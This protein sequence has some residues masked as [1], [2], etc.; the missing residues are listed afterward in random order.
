[1][2]NYGDAMAGRSNWAASPMARLGLVGM[3]FVIGAGIGWWSMPNSAVPANDSSTYIGVARNLTSDEQR[4]HG[5][6]SPFSHELSGLSPDEAVANIGHQPVTAWPPLYPASLAA[7]SIV[8]LSIESV[9]RL[10]NV[11][12]FGI[13][14]ALSAAMVLRL[15]GSAI[16][17]GL[18]AVLFSC[19]ISTV[20]VFAIAGTEPLYLA[21]QVGALAV[22]GS[23]ARR[24]T[25]GGCV[26]FVA[27]AAGAALTRYVGVAVVATGVLMVWTTAA[28]VSRVRRL[29][30]GAGMALAALPVAAWLLNVRNVPGFHGDLVYQHRFDELTGTIRSI[31]E[32]FVPQDQLQGWRVPLA[33][34]GGVVVVGLS[35]L[36]FAT[37][38]RRSPSRPVDAPGA[39][40][41]STHPADTMETRDTTDTT[42]TTGT[43]HGHIASLLEP[44][45]PDLR[46]AATIIVHAVLYEI[47]VLISASFADHA[48]PLGYRLTLPLAPS[49]LALVFA[50]TERALRAIPQRTW[51]I[52]ACSAIAMLV[53]VAIG[54]Q[55]RDSYDRVLSRS[56][57]GLWSTVPSSAPIEAVRALPSTT[58]VFTNQPSAI[59]GLTGRP[60]LALPLVTSPMTGAANPN[61]ARDVDQLV[62][63]L[64]SGDTVLVIDPRTAF[65]TDGIVV[66]EREL[67]ARIDLEV[68]I[69][70]GDHRVLRAR[71]SDA[72][73]RSDSD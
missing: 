50:G 14:A 60:V 5:I 67:R 3:L 30:V 1:L 40:H 23:L 48:I 61:A 12:A 44:G 66:S 29:A 53:V 2:Q 10:I 73:N 46:L 31:G 43:A 27:L 39:T 62:S 59:Y 71:D 68:V 22:A 33:L 65:F 8:S 38:A 45:E 32:W 41:Q 63:M 64:A 9:A 24:V 47:F 7:G 11:L 54:L 51:R 49:I 58:V 4:V 19:G 42:D 35:C 16:A 34:L 26:A 15:G 28:P 20:T 57:A 13:V 25:I 17:A 72:G 70:D 36:A 21:L 52:V 18:A 69:E 6:T 37:V 55:G 56:P